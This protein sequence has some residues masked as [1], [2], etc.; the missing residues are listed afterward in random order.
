[1]IGCLRVNLCSVVP[2]L[3]LLAERSLQRADLRFYYEQK[4]QKGVG[5][6]NLSL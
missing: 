6:N 1:M 3:S 2:L 4:K 5:Q